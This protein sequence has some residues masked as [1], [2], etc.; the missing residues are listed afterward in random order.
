MTNLG[1]KWAKKLRRAVSACFLNGWGVKTVQNRALCIQHLGQRAF[2]KH[3]EMCLK[4]SK[5]PNQP[6][7]LCL[8]LSAPNH[9]T[10]GRTSLL[11]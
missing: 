10:N 4:E 7:S 2:C 1:Q 5:Y 3:T 6:L 11:S 8:R 9:L